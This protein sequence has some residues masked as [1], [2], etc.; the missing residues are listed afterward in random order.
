MAAVACSASTIVAAPAAFLSSDRKV[1]RSR[2]IVS[3]AAPSRAASRVTMSAEKKVNSLALPTTVAL[4]AAAVLP[5]IAEAAQPGVSPS[6]K[7]LLLS[8]L[9]GGVIAG[10]IG[11]AVAGVSSFDPINRK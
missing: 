2:N 3:L 5:E 7:N 10:A 11:I 9:A 4:L 6:L 8:V 1:L